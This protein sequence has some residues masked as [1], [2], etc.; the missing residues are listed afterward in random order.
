MGC[1]NGPTQRA[2]QSASVSLAP[3]GWL[4]SDTCHWHLC[5]LCS[6]LTSCTDGPS[7]MP[8]SDWVMDDRWHWWVTCGTDGPTW[9][10]SLTGD[11]WHWWANLTAT[12]TGDLWH[13]WA[14][15]TAITDG[16]LVVLM[17]QPDS[18]AD[19]WL[20]ALMGQ[21]D[22]HHWRVTC[23]TDGP[24]WRLSLTGDL[25][26]WRANLMIGPC[27][28]GAYLTGHLV[29]PIPLPIRSGQWHGPS[30]WLM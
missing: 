16:W 23:G 14:H 6:W 28:V 22:G 27:S 15:L 19:G 18:H 30:C 26:H 5:C 12:L 8:V 1:R 9:R 3:S 21:P 4:I 24:T 2:V 11:L 29:G 7:L 13:W 17:G 20:V 10:P 25:W